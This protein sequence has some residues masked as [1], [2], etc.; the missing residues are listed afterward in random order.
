M[1][2][3]P[4]DVPHPLA[5]KMYYSQ[6]VVRLRSA[7]SYMYHEASSNDSGN[8]FACPKVLKSNVMPADI[9]C[10]SNNSHILINYQQEKVS[11]ILLCVLVGDTLYAL[12]DCIVTVSSILLLWDNIWPFLFSSGSDS[13]ICFIPWPFW[14]I[15][16]SDDYH[17]LNLLGHEQI[18]TILLEKEYVYTILLE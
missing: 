8:E 16:M 15:S 14:L 2:C 7:L 18:Y 11:Q 5:T 17:S 4:P 10:H 1:C 9:L 13:Y 12:I 6:R 3:L